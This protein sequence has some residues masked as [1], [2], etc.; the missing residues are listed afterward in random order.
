MKRYALTILYE[1]PD[2]TSTENEKK[3]LPDLVQAFLMERG[4]DLRFIQLET[5]E[6]DGESTS[7]KWTP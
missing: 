3:R 1:A 6:Q 5:V 4:Y 2:K 7:A